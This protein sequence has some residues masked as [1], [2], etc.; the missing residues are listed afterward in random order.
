MLRTN[1]SYI[2]EF[3]QCDFVLEALNIASKVIEEA[4]YDYD[5]AIK[6]NDFLDFFEAG[7]DKKKTEE[8]KEKDKKNFLE[9]IGGA[10]LSAIH[11]LGNFIKRIGGIFTKNVEDVRTEEDILEDMLKDNPWLKNQVIP[12]FEKGWF[13][14]T[15]R[16]ER[17]EIPNQNT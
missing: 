16:L 15:C 3:S 13:C 5:I 8:K 7:A 12:G 10:I 1:V 17:H 4:C 9:K 14:R 11:A 6:N 2:N